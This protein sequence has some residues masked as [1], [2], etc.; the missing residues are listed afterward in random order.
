MYNDV[1]KGINQ[2]HKLFLRDWLT[3]PTLSNEPLTKVSRPPFFRPKLSDFFA[4][5]IGAGTAPVT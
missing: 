1:L 4:E 3:V 5:Q 2:I